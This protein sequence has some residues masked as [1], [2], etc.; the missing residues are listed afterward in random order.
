MSRRRGTPSVDA[1][2]QGE[3]MNQTSEVVRAAERLEAD[4]R[5]LEALDLLRTVGRDSMDPDLE[6]HLLRLHYAAFAQLDSPRRRDVWLPPAADAL[7]APDTIPEVGAGDLTSAVVHRALADHGCLLVRGLVRPDQVRLLKQDTDRA[8][9]A[10]D[11]AVAGAP[12]E[13]TR[14][15]F[16]PFMSGGPKKRKYN[17]QVSVRTVDSPRTFNDVM[18]VFGD[19][20]VGALVAEFFG[21]RPAMSVN[22]CELRRIPGGPLRTPDFHQDGSFLGEDIIALNVWL[23]LTDCGV[24]APSLDVV[25]RRPAGVLPTGVNRAWQPWTVSKFTVAE[26]LDDPPVLRPVFEPGDALL[27]DHLLVHRTG[28]AE[29]M[30]GLRY[31]VENWFFAPSAYPQIDPNH[32]RAHL[33]L[34][35]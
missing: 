30:Q 32:L 5:L 27:F 11:A 26:V 25:P 16:T 23:A 8:F 33:P 2:N 18:E 12:L 14:P 17:G 4:D 20:G 24:D 29:G 9:E 34:I 3:A 28:T 10:R 7:A 1:C 6:E 19:T 35:Y 22:K 15:W 21:E 31:A 13:S